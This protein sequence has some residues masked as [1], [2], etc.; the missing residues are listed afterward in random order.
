MNLAYTISNYKQNIN[1]LSIIYRNFKKLVGLIAYDNHSY[2][3]YTAPYSKYYQI[4]TINIYYLSK[5]IH[6]STL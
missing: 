3:H 2:E 1:W 5:Y 4:Y 6:N